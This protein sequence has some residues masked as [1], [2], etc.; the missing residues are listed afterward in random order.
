MVTL[1]AQA[2]STV[3]HTIPKTP[4]CHS[5]RGLTAWPGLQG[6]GLEGGVLWDPVCWQYGECGKGGRSWA[7]DKFLT[8]CHSRE[9]PPGC[10]AGRAHGRQ[11]RRGS[12]GQKPALPPC[13]PQL[14]SLSRQGPRLF[15]PSFLPSQPAWAAWRVVAR[16][17]LVPDWGAEELEFADREFGGIRISLCVCLPITAHGRAVR[18]GAWACAQ[19][20]RTPFTQTPG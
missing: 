19:F 14:P 9:I 7:Q 20:Q 16:R 3:T 15:L 17:P 6:P 11:G 10:G 8:V 4:T 18:M 13:P 1:Q 2:P 5:L 12:G